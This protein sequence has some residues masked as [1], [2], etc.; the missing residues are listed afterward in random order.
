LENL[1][2]E[3]EKQAVEERTK[4]NEETEKMKK[5][6]ELLKQREKELAELHKERERREEL[7]ALLRNEKE[8]EN[9]LERSLIEEKERL[10]SLER[11]FAEE[12]LKR[13]DIER[14]LQ[15]EET[16][17]RMQQEEKKKPVDTRSNSTIGNGHSLKRRIPSYTLS[18]RSGQ[19][20][21]N[22]EINLLHHIL[23]AGHV[24]DNC[25]AIKINRYSCR[26]YLLKMGKSR[27]KISWKKRWFVFDRKLRALCYYQDE[28]KTKSK[29]ILYFQSI[30]EV[31]VDSSIKRSPNSRTT[32]CVRTPQRTFFLCAPSPIAMSVWLDVICTGK[33]GAFSTMTL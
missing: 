23:A 2:R 29:G 18:L 15:E 31:Y 13:L 1:K 24:I 10:T 33:E 6:E 28:R 11:S 26:G 21:G 19:S 27:L 4:L 20:S 16:R 14:R 5:H 8:N 30:Q 22:E 17:N 25:P 32:F 9:L 7:E 12:K 3:Q